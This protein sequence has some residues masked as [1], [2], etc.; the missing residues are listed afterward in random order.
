M[1]ANGTDKGKGVEQKLGEAT[2]GSVPTE[3]NEWPQ[4]DP[5]AAVDP[6]APGAPPLGSTLA[7]EEMERLRDDVAPPEKGR[8]NIRLKWYYL[9]TAGLGVLTLF[10]SLYGATEVQNTYGGADGM[11]RQPSPLA[12][13][14]PFLGIGSLGVLVYL[15]IDAVKTDWADAK[16]VFVDTLAHEQNVTELINRL[17]DV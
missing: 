17:A 8:W 7:K 15:A 4:F 12:F 9:L 5:Q 2:S 11:R 6:E 3:R 13:F 16:E 1:M 10:I 14:L